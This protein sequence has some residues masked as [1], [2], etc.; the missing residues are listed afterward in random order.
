VINR[1]MFSQENFDSGSLTVLA[2]LVHKFS[3]E[4]T[5][6]GTVFRGSKVVG[7]FSIIVCQTTTST[8]SNCDEQIAQ[9]T[10]I[11]EFKKQIHID[12]KFLDLPVHQHLESLECNCFKLNLSGYAVFYVSTGKG[13]YAVEIKKVGLNCG[14]ELVFDSR[15][16]GVDD[17]FAVTVL[18]PGS[19]SITN[20][21]TKAKGELSVAYPEIGKIPRNPQTITIECDQKSITPN[22]IR[23]NPTQGIVFSFK[24]SSRIKIELIEPEDKPRPV[25]T[26]INGKATESLKTSKK[27]IRRHLKINPSLI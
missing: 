12:L 8:S 18:R 11:D 10:D 2:T 25:K 24:K 6:H 15:K 14:P 27:K 20:T 16:L 19:Y 1:Y 17:L 13:G 4:G 21:I 23:I 5:Y 26:K 22:K 3:E 7:Q 9:E